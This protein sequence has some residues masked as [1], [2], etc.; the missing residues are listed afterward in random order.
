MKIDEFKWKLAKYC[1]RLPT[2]GF[3]LILL[4]AFTI[5]LSSAFADEGDTTVVQTIDH[6]T[7]VN[8][9]WNQPREGYYLFPSDT[10]SWEKI[11]M[12]YTL[13]C[14]PLQNPACGE[15]DYLTYTNLHHHTGI[16][17]SNLF[18]H[19]NF[20]IAGQA[21]DSFMYMNTESWYYNVYFNFENNTAPV[22][23]A[24]IGSTNAMFIFN[25]PGS[26]SDARHQFIFTADQLNNAGLLTGDITGIE[27]YQ[28][29][30]GNTLKNLCIKLKS[31]ELEE[32]TPGSFENHDLTTVYKWDYTDPT[33][34]ALVNFPFAHPFSWDGISNIILDISYQD[35]NSSGPYAFG[36]ANTSS[37]NSISS[38]QEDDCIYLDGDYIEV[39]ITNIAQLDSAVSISFWQY[40]G[41][42]QPTNNSII[43]ATNED[44][45]RVLNVHMPWSNGSVY[46]DAGQDGGYDRINKGA[47]PED[48]K[49]R[50]NHWV[51]TKDVNSGEMRIY[52]NGIPWHI[53]TGKTRP[54]SGITSFIIGAGNPSSNF[55]QGKIDELAIFNTALDMNTI[56]EWAYKEIDPSHP[57]YSN[58][59]TYFKFNEGSGYEITS[60]D[61]DPV[62]ASMYGYPLWVGHEGERPTAFYQNQTI[63]YVGFQNG[64]YSGATLDSLL[65]VDTIPNSEVMI[66]MYENPQ[67]PLVST[68]TLSKWPHYY[69]YTFGPNGIPIDTTLVSPDG[70]LYKQEWPYYI[71]YEVIEKYELGRYI[72]PYGN[73]LSLGNGFTWVYDV[74]DFVQFLHDTVHLSA[75]NFQELL[76]LDF[77]M[78]EGT[79]P[80]DVISLDRL[81]H[82]NYGLSNFENQVLPDT[83]ELDPEAEMFSVKIT[84]SGHGWD[85]ATNCAEFCQKTHW[86]D[87]NGNTEYSWEILDE[88][89]TNPLYPQGGTWIYDRAGWCP[90]AKV[91]EQNLEITDFVSGSSAIIDYNAESD[92]YGNYVVRSYFL[93]YSAPNFTVDAAV[94][95]IIKPNSKKFYGRFNPMCG[96]PEIVIKNTG[97]EVLYSL[98]INYAP[99]GANMQTYQWTGFLNFLETDTIVV[100]AIDWTGWLNGNNTFNVELSNPNGTQDEYA[101]NNHYKTSFA[102]SP[103]FDNEFVINFKTNKVAYQNRYEIV[104]SEGTVVYERD[105]FENLTIYK[106][107]V[108]LADG[109]YTYTLYDSGDNGISFWANTQGTGFLYFKDL[110]GTTIHNF[111]GDFGRF[112]SLDF[113]IGMAVNLPQNNFEGHIDVF[114]NP[115]NDQVNIAIG[116]EYKQDVVLRIFD[117]SGKEIISKEYTNSAKITDR[118]N[119][120]FLENG[121]YFISIQTA[122]GVI[123][124]K[125][126]IKN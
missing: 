124:R 15:W 23:T 58:L 22:N 37:N 66:V 82:G 48:Y 115:A 76:D 102:L 36:A 93:Q 103:E 78:I 40:G 3:R 9:G 70:I 71:P 59:I 12:Y 32:I 95:D 10:M 84:T 113:S 112:T 75:G 69:E 79:P 86:L 63:P 35:D 121:M 117:I 101:P 25:D 60:S 21:P 20:L 98:D 6:N 83:V 42:N 92:A 38:M 106:D 77:I 28:K 94:E 18:Y 123:N 31:T 91:T 118:I 114:P 57:N 85:N 97:S 51:F 105:D 68:D 49:G 61:P 74:S 4:I 1:F 120:S 104:D 56:M 7:P 109:C 39:P 45:E 88:C 41:V 122:E 64:N 62:T 89:S 116:L 55:Y 87:V 27:L 46:W 81:W 2:S 34:N 11:L 43:H 110:T 8:P 44:G 72:T 111:K 107:T 100:D 14:D 17:D 73:N 108:L 30:A 52:L 67:N 99:Q 24:T 125:L 65:I 50:W 96:R 119:T 19:P 47:N 29:S 54:M 5:M 90:G 53:G 80:R 26:S 13:K 16:I 33:V 126:I